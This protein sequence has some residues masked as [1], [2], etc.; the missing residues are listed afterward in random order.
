M[1]NRRG[2]V[3]CR[4][5]TYI[6]QPC[7]LRDSSVSFENRFATS[8]SRPA[9]AIQVTAKTTIALLRLLGSCP[10]PFLLA[11]RGLEFVGEF[12][13]QD[14]L[15]TVGASRNHPH[16]RPCLFLNKR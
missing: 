5:T 12:F 8:V 4:C 13:H 9:F 14:G 2:S 6:R 11:R 16:P 15:F 3:R 10:G 7:S 1:K